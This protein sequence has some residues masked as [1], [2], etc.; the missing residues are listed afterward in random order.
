VKEIKA[1][2]MNQ[3]TETARLLRQPAQA[4][5]P[6][7][8]AKGLVA[9][10][11]R[12]AELLEKSGL[13]RLEDTLSTQV[14]PAKA[15]IM[16]DGV[17]EQVKTILDMV[18]AAS[19]TTVRDVKAEIAELDGLRGKSE[20]VIRGTIEA[21]E[22]EKVS[23]DKQV[24]SFGK[25]DTQLK[26]EMGA[27]LDAL[28]PER[29]DKIFEES[30]QTMKKSLTTRSLK[31]NMG[32]LFKEIEYS[33]KRAE[34][35]SQRIRG[36]IDKSYKGFSS[37]HNMPRMKPSQFNTKRYLLKLDALLKDAEAY[38]NSTELMMTEQNALVQKFMVTMVSHMRQLLAEAHD[39]AKKWSVSV[40]N[41][42]K[43]EISKHKETLDDRLQNLTKLKS[44]QLDI[45]ERVK[46][47]NGEIAE[48]E[49]EMQQLQSVLQRIQQSAVLPGIGDTP[50]LSNAPATTCRASFN[51]CRI[52][53]TLNRRRRPSTWTGHRPRQAC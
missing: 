6:V 49:A 31:G 2:I 8:A 20:G 22:Q 10:F 14:V 42:I 11:R 26:K 9:K 34:A 32:K 15:Q 16:R 53:S 28:D 35:Q 48:Q 21:L 52:T 12:D 40:L 45:D 44:S 30:R 23:F 46:A 51:I 18:K 39:A 13:A 38:R 25:I 50:F 24:A 3:L 29:H 33:M 1:N 43:R 19:T 4:I 5:F 41:P 37:E 47:L 17:V 36:H 27:F 7:S